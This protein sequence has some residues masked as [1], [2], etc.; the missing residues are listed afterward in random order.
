MPGYD[1]RLALYDAGVQTMGY[2]CLCYDGS[3]GNSLKNLQI[4]RFVLFFCMLC[5][6]IY[7]AAKR[8]NRDKS[9]R[10]GWFGAEKNRKVWTFCKSRQPFL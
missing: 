7:A 10:R 2:Q 8:R 3:A 1:K 4:R 9:E 5:K 6:P